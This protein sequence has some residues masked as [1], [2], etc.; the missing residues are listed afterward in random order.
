MENLDEMLGKLA[1][2]LKSEA[3]TE[4]I[5]G[6]QFQLGNFTCVPVISV[7]LG[8]GSGGGEGKGKGT[9]N[10]N[11]KGSGE[12]EG[13][14]AMGAAGIGIGPVGFLAVNGNEIQFV[15]TRTSKG[16]SALFEK[17]PDIVEK[18]FEKNHGK[19]AAHN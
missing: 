3:R 19:E 5:I 11:A 2:F 16:I 1:E 6:Q 18:I 10:S 14:G 7:G 15:S 9:G 4:T 8:L 13:Y 17:A 12:G